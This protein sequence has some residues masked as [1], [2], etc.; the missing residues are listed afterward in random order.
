MLHNNNLIWIH[1][2]VLVDNVMWEVVLLVVKEIIY[3]FIFFLLT[4]EE[5]MTERLQNLLKVH[6]VRNSC[7]FLYLTYQCTTI[8]VMK[9]DE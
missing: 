3:V 5:E 2:C 8:L 4:D 9:P 1:F 7:I 6:E